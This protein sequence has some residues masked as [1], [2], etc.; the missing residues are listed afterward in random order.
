MSVEDHSDQVLQRRVKLEK[1]R[2]EGVSPYV[3]RFKPLSTIAEVRNR[4]EALDGPAL[5][6]A[7][8]DCAVGGRLMSLRRHGKVTFG[9]IR[10]GTGEIQIYLRRDA[11][12]PEEYGRLSA[13]DI[14]DF[15]GVSGTIFRTRTGELTV[16]ATQAQLLAKAL[17]PLPEK[18]HG[19]RD[20]ESRYRQRYVDLV[21]NPQ[22]REIFLLRSRIIQAIRDFLNAR[23][24]LEVETPMM[25]SVAG[26]AAAKPFITHHSALGMDLY[27]RIAPELFLKRLVVGGLDRVYELN[28]SFRNEGISTRHNPEFTML[29]FYMAYA[30]YTDLMT[31]TE[32]LFRYLAMT[33]LGRLNLTYQGSDI[34]LAQPWARYTFE[35]ALVRVGGLDPAVLDSRDR[36]RD[37]AHSLGVSV[38]K[39]DHFKLLDKLFEHLVEP[40]LIEP[41]FVVD[42]PVAMCPL[43]KTRPDDP[44]TA[45]RFEVF[46]GGRELV[47]AYTELN[48]PV[49]Q[50]RRFEEQM[51]CREA[52]DEEAHMMDWDYI[53]ALEY[54]MPPTAGEGV[55]VD[56]LVM[57]FTDS[58]SIRE[59]I[60]FPLLKREQ[61]EK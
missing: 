32:E 35:D 6:S 12:P 44:A 26:G 30:D 46:I 3:N 36:A 54:G 27:L 7:G 11:L 37:A 10:D 41:T 21:A 9:H 8:V 5:E 33:I 59:V 38:G 60:L 39:D 22:V 19:L 58:A 18:W 55:G 45:E 40:R 56:R 51:A 4:C 52:G 25:Q 29:E 13:F 43:A 23:G 20:V 31:M 16:A 48:D 50:L 47:N 57:L 34:D 61:P 15:L 1:L 42:F 28:R 24:F 17:R 14:G 49:E 2:A 53:R